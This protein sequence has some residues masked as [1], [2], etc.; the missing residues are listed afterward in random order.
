M[1]EFQTEQP[2]SQHSRSSENARSMDVPELVDRIL[3]INPTA[4]GSYLSG[5]GREALTH[6]LDHLSVTRQPRGRSEGW[7]R[8][9][10]TPGIVA[11]RAREA[12]E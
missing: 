7:V 3:E 9:A 10:E 8:R 6:Y 4:G 12:R 5:F 1:R 2:S 11:R